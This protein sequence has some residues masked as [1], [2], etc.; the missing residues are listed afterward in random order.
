MSVWCCESQE[1]VE[2]GGREAWGPGLG[3][4]Q[5]SSKGGIQLMETTQ[6][7]LDRVT[8]I[9]HW[10]GNSAVR[11]AKSFACFF[12]FIFLASAL[13]S[14]RSVQAAE[15]GAVRSY[16]LI[17]QETPW[18]ITP[19]V[20]FTAWTYNGSIPGPVI[21]VVAGDTIQVRLVNNLSVPV[22]LHPH[23][24]IYDIHNDGSFHTGSFAPPGGEYVY[25]WKT[26]RDTIGAWL[27]HD[28]VAGSDRMMGGGHMRMG[29]GGMAEDDGDSVVG[30]A[31]GLYGMIVVRPHNQ[32]RVEREYF[33]F[34]GEFM[35]QLT[36]VMPPAGMEMLAGF[37][38]KSWPSTPTLVAR[39]G[40]SVR[41]YV[42]SVG[43]ESH[44]FHI[45]GHRWKDPGTRLTIDAKQIGPFETST[46]E[47]TAGQNGP[48]E[49]LYHCHDLMHL[50]EGMKGK[51]VVE[52]RS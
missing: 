11:E 22:S 46:F 15:P 31:R 52:P 18:V 21:D 10:A 47:V 26:S 23:G 38:G 40:E 41:F 39:Q 51:F 6:R 32:R 4:N 37:N 7:F 12:C 28:H 20:N 17:A 13:L 9:Q 27:Y 49:W 44:T 3:V 14:I 33:L 16:T 50:M 29:N 19:E 34:M 43:T 48:G 25:T 5:D 24:V 36:G 8:N 30:I 35:P 42:A 1:G 45:H 2:D